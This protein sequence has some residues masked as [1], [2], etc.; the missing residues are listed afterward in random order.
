M[1]IAVIAFRVRETKYMIYMDPLTEFLMKNNC[2]SLLAS[3]HPG[4]KRVPAI[5]INAQKQP[6]LGWCRV[7]NPHTWHGSAS[8]GNPAG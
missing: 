6:N 2:F 5:W 3:R 8:A 4:D 7:G 1:P